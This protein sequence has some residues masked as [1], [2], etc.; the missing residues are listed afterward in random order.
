LEL[1]A[2]DIWV[3]MDGYVLFVRE[4]FLLTE[5]HMKV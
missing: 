3:T 5:A 4:R 1:I 2:P